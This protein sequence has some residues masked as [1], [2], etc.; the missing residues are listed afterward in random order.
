MIHKVFHLLKA[1][2]KNHANC[3]FYHLTNLANN[4]LSLG[5]KKKAALIFVILFSKSL[6][7][8]IQYFIYVIAI[9]CSLNSL[10]NLGR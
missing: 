5:V 10:F 6:I 9:L 7:S 4:S 3:Y 1:L 8:L 2:Y